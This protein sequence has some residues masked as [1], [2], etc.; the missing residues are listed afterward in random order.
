MGSRKLWK[1][2]GNFICWKYCRPFIHINLLTYCPILYYTL[3]HCY[4][5][6]SV[7]LYPGAVMG[8]FHCWLWTPG[9]KQHCWLCTPGC[10]QHLPINYR[11]VSGI[12]YNIVYSETV[13]GKTT[14]TYTSFTVLYVVVQTFTT[15]P[16]SLVV[17]VTAV[18]IKQS[19]KIGPEC[20]IWKPVYLKIEQTILFTIYNQYKYR[21]IGILGPACPYSG[22]S[23]LISSFFFSSQ[24]HN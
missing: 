10:K 21:Y 4:K 13:R 22:L 23:V 7:Y 12:E 5:L 3:L 16:L 6:R 17:G 2:M 24:V 8:Y 18:V 9:C 19:S 15:V 20:C 1:E 11:I 14:Y